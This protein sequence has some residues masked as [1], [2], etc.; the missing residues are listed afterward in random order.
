MRNIPN[1]GRATEYGYYSNGK[2]YNKNFELVID[3]GNNSYSILNSSNDA[4]VFYSKQVDGKTHY[5]RYD[6]NG[7]A[8]ITA[9]EGR[10]FYEYSPISVRGEYYMVCHSAANAMYST[11][12]YS[13]YTMNGELLFTSKENGSY[14][15]FTVLARSDDAILVSYIDADTNETVYKRLAK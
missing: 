14:D 13:V 3:L 7:E 9:P 10:E 2:I 8:E 6:K 1:V 12:L 5:Y 11:S 15:V 4:A